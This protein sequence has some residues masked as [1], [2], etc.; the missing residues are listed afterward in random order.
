M[1]KRHYS[2]FIAA[3]PE[4]LHFA[5]HSHHYWPDVTREAILT[6]WDDA[7]YLVDEKWA[8]IFCVAV[9]EAQR[10]IARILGLSSPQ[11]I[12]FAP[13]T[14]EF[15][16][17]LLSAY[18]WSSPLRVL[19]T[20][21]EFLSFRRQIDRLA[22]LST[23]TVT[24]VPTMPFESFEERFK[25]AAAEQEFDFIFFSQVFFDSGYV[26]RDLEGIVD[27]VRSAKTTI[28]VDGYHAFCALPTS[29]SGIENRLFYLGG[30]YKYGQS[31]EGICFLAV[32]AGCTLRP[33]NTGWFAAFEQ[34]TDSGELSVEYADDAFRFWGS[35]F[36][37][38]GLYRF[39]AVMDWMKRN[40]LTVPVIHD[41]IMGLE[42]YFLA[43]IAKLKST[44]F[45]SRTQLLPDSVDRAHFITYRLKDAAKVAEELERRKIIV[46]YRGDRLRFGFGLYQTRED[47]DSLRT[48]LQN[49]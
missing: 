40:G 25:K 45:N 14:H 28:V 29:L 7:A 1:Y 32:P 42:N 43:E 23:V 48:R 47:V 30:G 4:R 18:D 38:G 8:R 26:V 27:A 49:R 3:D 21:S 36:D 5:A 33:V 17:R 39:N 35:T 22:E 44:H 19:T 2:R 41:Y 6:C 15:A 9:P 13:N 46:D 31:G 34:L 10:H 16:I 24:R 11:N 20:D 12:A 37:P